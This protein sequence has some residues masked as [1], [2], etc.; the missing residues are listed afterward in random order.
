M[1]LADIGTFRPRHDE[2]LART[3]FDTING[4]HPASTASTIKQ[5][6]RKL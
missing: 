4:S 2:A 6:L 3:F 1:F 5:E